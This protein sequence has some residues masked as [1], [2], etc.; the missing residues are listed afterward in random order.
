MRAYRHREISLL[1]MRI[2]NKPDMIFRCRTRYRTHIR[3]SH[4]KYG[5][6]YEE[7]YKGIIK[8][9]AKY[10]RPIF[11]LTLLSSIMIHSKLLYTTAILSGDGMKTENNRITLNSV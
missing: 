1:G 3:T 8:I 7:N 9:N 2:P 6:D 11:N 5:N 10:W 4:D